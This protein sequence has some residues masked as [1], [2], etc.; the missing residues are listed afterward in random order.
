MIKPILFLALMWLWTSMDFTN[1]IA[2]SDVNHG[3][4]GQLLDDTSFWSSLKQV[5]QS[6]F[7]QYFQ[8][9]SVLC[10][11][12]SCQEVRLNIRQWT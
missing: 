7:S 9:H 12:L 6:Y 4:S 5:W 1:S 2:E 8:N 3:L 11:R 10:N